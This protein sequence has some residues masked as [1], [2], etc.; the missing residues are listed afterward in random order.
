M[1]SGFILLKKKKKKNS[2]LFFCESLNHVPCKIW[3]N[4]VKLA[5]TWKKK[6]INTNGCDLNLAVNDMSTKNRD[7]NESK[8]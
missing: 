1:N 7:F 2:G 6:L 5:Y 4:R 3:F 8:F